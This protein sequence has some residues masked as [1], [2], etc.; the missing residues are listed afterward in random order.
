M[1][2]GSRGDFMKNMKKN[3]KKW[4][5]KRAHSE[6]AERKYVALRGGL[7]RKFFLGKVL[8]QQV[9]LHLSKEYRNEAET[10]ALMKLQGGIDALTKIKRWTATK[11]EAQK[12]WMLAERMRLDKKG[13][14]TKADA[15]TSFLLGTKPKIIPADRPS[16]FN[17]KPTTPY[18]PRR[19]SSKG[20]IKT[21][22]KGAVKT[23]KAWRDFMNAIFRLGGDRP[24]TKI[25]RQIS[26]T[27][28]L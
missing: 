2:I 22:Q 26:K 12:Y 6:Q 10:E 8:E 24:T 23:N 5:G 28:D 3:K 18:Y 15:V 20:K 4:I 27:M 19:G 7:S 13:G 1:K 21:I 9:R 17:A 16:M 14:L 25:K 11:A